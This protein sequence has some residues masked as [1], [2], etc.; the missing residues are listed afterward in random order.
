MRDL[1][2]PLPPGE[3]TIGQL[4][5]ESI[6]FYGNHFWKAIPLGIPLALVDQ[7]CAGQPLAP[8]D[9][10]LLGGN[11]VHRPRVRPRLLARVRAS[12]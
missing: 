8:S 3:R 1:P 2:P 4:I 10:D 7:L 9:A 12:R 5:A 11:A 6:R